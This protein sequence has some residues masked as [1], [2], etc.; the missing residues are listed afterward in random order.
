VSGELYDLPGLEVGDPLMAEAMTSHT[1]V[2]YRDGPYPMA[3][4]NCFSVRVD[5]GEEYRIVNFGYENLREAIRRGITWPIQILPIALKLAVI[6][7]TRIPDSWYSKQ[8]CETCCPTRFLPPPQRLAHLRD[9]ERGHR[10][11]T[12]TT[13]QYPL[14][15]NHP[16]LAEPEVKS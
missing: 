5:P 2:G 4:G 10:I 9:I 15:R 6:H 13:V 16:V 8:W 7:D 14:P 12:G 11:E 1:L 3:S